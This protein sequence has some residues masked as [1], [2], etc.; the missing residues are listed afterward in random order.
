MQ[1]AAVILCLSNV[2]VVLVIMVKRDLV[3]E[4]VS[5][6]KITDTPGRGGG[7]ALPY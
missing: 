7:G 3:Q 5:L 1:D 6:S 2:P 4:F